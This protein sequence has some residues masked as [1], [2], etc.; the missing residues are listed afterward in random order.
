[1]ALGIAAGDPSITPLALCVTLRVG[2]RHDCHR[3]T[4]RRDLRQ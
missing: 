2:V 4:R 3:R 1:M